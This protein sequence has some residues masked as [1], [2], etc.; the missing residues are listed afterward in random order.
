MKTPRHVKQ[1]CNGD[2]RATT[3]PGKERIGHWGKCTL[4]LS[5]PCVLVTLAL[6]RSKSGPQRVSDN[7]S[8]RILSN[9]PTS[10]PTIKVSTAES[11]ITTM[12]QT[13]LAYPST[14]AITHHKCNGYQQHLSRSS[15]GDLNDY[16]AYLLPPHL[17]TFGN[18]HDFSL[19]LLSFNQYLHGPKCTL[20]QQSAQTNTTHTH[21]MATS[22]SP[23]LTN[24]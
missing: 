6:C 12:P 2:M 15:D 5:E 9:T 21:A 22:K 11:N 14:K 16:P 24:K 17:Q 13:P 3:S 23:N 4:V 1:M 10:Q 20:L 8:H 19:C 18:L 7:P